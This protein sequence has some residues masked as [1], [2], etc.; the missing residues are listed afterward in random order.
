[1]SAC[2][3]P[4]HGRGPGVGGLA[5]HR[6][7]GAVQR[8][9]GAQHPR[10][11]VPGTAAPAAGQ[12]PDGLLRPR[13]RG[14][15]GAD[16]GPAGRG[17]QAR[18]DQEAARHHRWLHRAGRAVHP[19]RPRA[20]RARGPADRAPRRAR[21]TVREHRRRRRQ[22]RG[23]DGPA[24]RAGRRHLRGDQPAA[25]ERRRRADRSRHPDHPLARR[26]GAAA[27]ARRRRRPALRRPVPRRDLA[28]L[29]RRGPSRRPVA[30]RLRDH[31][32]D[33]PH[34]RRGHDRRAGAG[35]GRA[36][37]RHLRPRHR[38]QREDHERGPT[39]APDAAGPSADGAEP[40]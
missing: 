11:P 39:V 21:R 17:R 38:A 8:C 33:A 3:S 4:C 28:A 40:S 14:A 19:D 6:R 10:L 32:A 37:R 27:Q 9:H 34:L 18:H 29:R 36:G 5:H 31:R 23:Q 2:Y 25:D 13:S 20:V 35:R 15:S 1:M 12:G 26:R 30:A 7:A 22:A 24:A 16:P